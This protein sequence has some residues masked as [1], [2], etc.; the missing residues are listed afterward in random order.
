MIKASL[1]VKDTVTPRL[2]QL[3][4]Q[5]GPG[6]RRA[7]MRRLG[8]GLETQLREHFRQRNQASN[9]ESKRAARGFPQSG[10]WARIRDNTA[11]RAADEGSA[12]VG[13]GEP[14]F[15]TK[16]R[17]A[18]IRP[19][20]GKQYLAIPLR[21]EVYGHGRRPQGNPVPGLFFWKSKA[22]KAFLATGGSGGL[23]VWYRLVTQVS[24]PADPRALPPT[25]EVERAFAAILRRELARPAGGG[26]AG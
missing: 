14:A 4:D 10:L 23:Q 19:G 9:S 16:A 1:K 22:G 17:G 6:R 11:M 12:V 20:P 3:W 25:R 18:T 8:L 5:V 15:R 7:L 13:V 2:E 21:A 26:G 24:V